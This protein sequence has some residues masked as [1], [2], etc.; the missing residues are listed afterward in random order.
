MPAELQVNRFPGGWWE[1][2][3]WGGRLWFKGLFL[4][5]VWC[6]TGFLPLL[7]F[8][9]AL[10][11]R[12]LPGIASRDE[13]RESFVIFILS[14]LRPSGETVLVDSHHHHHH[15]PPLLDSTQW[16]MLLYNYIVWSWAWTTGDSLH[17]YFFFN[18]NINRLLIIICLMY[19]NHT[20]IWPLTYSNYSSAACVMDQHHQI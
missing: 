13:E 18:T 3:S 2:H 9:T 20:A 19:T 7:L 4:L 15:H 6:T 11:R 14:T 12:G 5:E 16:G 1:D 17:Y 8:T 10:H